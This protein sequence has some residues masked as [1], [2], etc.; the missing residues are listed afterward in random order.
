MTGIVWNEK[1]ETAQ[2]TVD[3]YVPGFGEPTT[4][5]LKQQLVKKNP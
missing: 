3:L 4:E 2:F 5:E 1:K